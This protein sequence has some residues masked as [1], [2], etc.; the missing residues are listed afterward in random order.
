LR[1]A[2]LQYSGLRESN[3]QKLIAYCKER[4]ELFGEAQAAVNQTA[5]KDGLSYPVMKIID[6]CFWIHGD[7]EFAEESRCG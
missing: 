4:E 2:G 6:M 7:P 5:T 3:F 1:R